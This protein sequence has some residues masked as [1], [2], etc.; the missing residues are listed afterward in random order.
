MLTSPPPDLLGLALA[1]SAL[2][3]LLTLVAAGAC[4]WALWALSCW[5]GRRRR[6]QLCANRVAARYSAYDTAYDT[7]CDSA[8]YAVMSGPFGRRSS[9]RQRLT[10]LSPHT[11]MKPLE[12][13]LA[14]IETLPAIQT[15]TPPST[16]FLR[17]T[18]RLPPAAPST[19][20]A[21]MPLAAPFT[22]PHT[23]G[24]SGVGGSAGGGA[25]NGADNWPPAAAPGAIIYRYIFVSGQLLR[26]SSL[27][28]YTL[29]PLPPECWS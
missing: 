20:S 1:Q 17:Q 12:V 18:P 19:V 4:A 26:L 15:V 23:E 25:D 27:R 21:A 3:A 10:Q 8:R 24:A 29:Y 9:G 7:T 22:R 2:G 16:A 11:P 13:D 28:R 6:R 14:R 5:M